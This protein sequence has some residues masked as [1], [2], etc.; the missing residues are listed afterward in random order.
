VEVD[1]LELKEIQQIQEE[2]LLRIQVLVEVV[3]DHITVQAEMD[4]QGDVSSK[5]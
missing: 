3:V 4:Q 1:P 2:Q 5:L